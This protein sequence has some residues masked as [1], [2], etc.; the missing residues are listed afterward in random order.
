MLPVGN[1]SLGL[2]RTSRPFRKVRKNFK[3]QTVRKQDLFFPG[4]Q[5]FKLLQKFKNFNLMSF[6]KIYLVYKM[7]E[8]IS[9]DLVW[10][11]KFGCVVLS[12]N[13]NAMI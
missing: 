5:T 1:W 9:P 12:G 7:F 2:Y 3:I 8:D 13:S 6:N 4:R 10:Y 11:C